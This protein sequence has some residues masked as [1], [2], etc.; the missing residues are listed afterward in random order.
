M[1]QTESGRRRNLNL[2]PKFIS[3]TVFTLERVESTILP[4]LIALPIHD[5]KLR[6]SHTHTLLPT[7][8]ASV[9]FGFVLVRVRVRLFFVEVLSVIIWDGLRNSRFAFSTGYV[10]CVL[11]DMGFVI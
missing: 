5:L 9:S 3:C 6:A 11:G 8:L 1:G 10:T 7:E 2:V 4:S